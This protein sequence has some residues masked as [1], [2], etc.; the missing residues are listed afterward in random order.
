MDAAEKLIRHG[1]RKDYVD[2]TDAIE[3]VQGRI[4]PVETALLNVMGVPQAKCAFQEFSD[5]TALNR[6]VKAAC[7]RVSRISSLNL[8]TRAR[9]RQ[10]AFR[11]D[12]VGVSQPHDL[13]VR[14]DRLS[15]SY[16]TVLP[17]ALL[18]LSGLGISVSVG[19][20]LGTAYLV[21]TPE[22]IEDGLRSILKSGLDGVS[23]S[24]RRLMLGDSGLSINPDLVF[25]DSRAVG[26]VKYRALG[27]DWS[28]PD[29]N[30]IVTFATGFRATWAAVFGFSLGTDDKLPR[31]ISVGE[32][33]AVVFSWKASIELKP[34][35]SAAR[36]LLDVSNWL[37]KVSA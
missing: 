17:L 6:I 8:S 37:D 7:Q 12:D 29:L 26:D 14:V 32:V 33:S 2:V 22:L 34:E 3:Q 11:M 18:V 31:D 1:L 15:S 28:K 30:Q 5:D 13:R 9:A 27:K 25:G 24:K 36:L 19:R 21:R 16:S 35:Q 4:L 23:V 10:V 20:Q